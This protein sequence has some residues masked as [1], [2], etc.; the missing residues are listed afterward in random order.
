M[1]KYQ[2]GVEIQ[3]KDVKEIVLFLNSLTARSFEKKNSDGSI[4]NE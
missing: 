4:A 2:L 3:D 1:G